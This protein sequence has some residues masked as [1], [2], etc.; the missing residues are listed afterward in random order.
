M[1]VNVSKSAALLEAIAMRKSYGSRL[2]LDGVSLA[3][4]AGDVVGLLSPNGTS[5]TTTLSLLATL[6]EPDGGT[7]RIAGAI[8]SPK[9]YAPLWRETL[10]S[11]TK[12]DPI[13]RARANSKSNSAARNRTTAQT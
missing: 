6:I 5:K 13:A 2:V 11:D 1:L 3:V 7:V 9:Q 8:P 4:N 12:T 10:W